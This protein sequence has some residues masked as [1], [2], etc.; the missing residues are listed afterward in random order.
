[1]SEGDTALRA[2]GVPPE[3]PS[4]YALALSEA[5]IGG[6]AFVLYPA[7]LD[8]LS[9]YERIVLAKTS[10]RMGY[11]WRVGLD[12]GKMTLEKNPEW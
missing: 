11:H 3:E 8:R 2:T 1:M 6:E 12:T 5:I 10:S 9:E 4:N 7:D